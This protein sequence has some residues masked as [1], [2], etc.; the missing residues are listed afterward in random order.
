ADLGV[1]GA[2]VRAEWDELFTAYSK[3]YPELADELDK[4]QRRQLPENWDA[5]LP[6][7]PADAKGAAGRDTNQKV[8]NIIAQRVPW[9]IGGSSDLAPS[10]KSRL[11]FEGAGD[12]Q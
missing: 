2:E 6:E 8:L 3:E 12:F 4:M 11:T 7:Y 5:D 10:N 1:H 9:L